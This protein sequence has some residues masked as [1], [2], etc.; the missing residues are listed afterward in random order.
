MI[1]VRDECMFG[2]L[3]SEKLQIQSSVF[4]MKQLIFDWNFSMN[5]TD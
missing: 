3:E 4:I 5:E 1:L 2:F